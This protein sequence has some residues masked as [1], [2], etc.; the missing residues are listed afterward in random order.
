LGDGAPL[1]AGIGSILVTP[2]ELQHPPKSQ[3]RRPT[4]TDREINNALWRAFLLGARVVAD[5]N[6]KDLTTGDIGTLGGIVR[7]IAE[8]DTTLEDPTALAKKH[9]DIGALLMRL[10]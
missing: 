4:M 3:L 9:P 7:Q 8:S 5:Q 2:Y 10:G 1:S 6:G